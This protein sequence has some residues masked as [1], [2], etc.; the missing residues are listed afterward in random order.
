MY[1]W[2]LTENTS[3]TPYT[4]Y[5]VKDV[6]ENYSLFCK[7]RENIK[8]STLQRILSPVVLNQGV[9]RIDTDDYTNKNDN[10]PDL[11]LIYKAKL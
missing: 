9:Y 1:V 10:Y 3:P 5:S 7:P 6:Q 11:Y 2:H 8:R 4:S